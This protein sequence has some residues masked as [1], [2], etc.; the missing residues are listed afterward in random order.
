MQL[1]PHLAHSVDTG[2]V[3]M[4]PG[5]LG[6]QLL[7]AHCSGAAPA[8][9]MGVVP[10]RGDLHPVLAEHPADRLDAEAVTVGLDVAHKRGEGRS[11]PGREKSRRRF[12]DLVGPAQLGVLFLQP[13][14][15][16]Q[17]L[18]G[19]TR[20]L[21]SVDLPAPDPLADRLTRGDAQLVSDRIHRR[22][23]RLV[24][25]PDFLHHSQRSL[26]HF[27]RILIRHTLILLKDQS[28]H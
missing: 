21:T 19:N 3:L 14:D 22:P 20:P 13:P 26:A 2:I 23:V 4:N 10:A 8:A 24:I 11:S 5:N 18:R 25:R 12:Q 16:S 6:L 15:L 7:I 27:S 17:L 1:A 28:L 9:A